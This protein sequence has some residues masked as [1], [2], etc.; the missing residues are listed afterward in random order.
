MSRRLPV[1]L[2]GAI[3]L[4][5]ATF[6]PELQASEAAL[7]VYSSSPGLQELALAD[8]AA[9]QLFRGR[10]RTEMDAQSWTKELKIGYLRFASPGQEDLQSHYLSQF[11]PRSLLSQV[12]HAGPRELELEE[13]LSGLGTALDRVRARALQALSDYERQRGQNLLLGRIPASIGDRSRLVS[14][15]E[16]LRDPAAILDLAPTALPIAVQYSDNPASMPEDLGLYFP[17]EEETPPDFLKH[18]A[19]LAKQQGLQY[20]LVGVIEALGIDGDYVFVEYLVYS[21][22][23]NRICLSSSF[24]SGR[25]E[26]AEIA[27][28]EARNLARRLVNRETSDLE[29]LVYP[30]VYDFELRDSLGLGAVTALGSGSFRYLA[31]GDLSLE[32]AYSASRRGEFS[33]WL[34]PEQ[35]A[36]WHV[37]APPPVSRIISVETE[38]AGAR[39][40]VDGTYAGLTPLLISTTANTRVLEFRKE[41]YHSRRLVLSPEQQR[42]GVK[43]PLLDNRVDWNRRVETTRDHFYAA[44]G[45]TILLGVLPVVFNGLYTD[46]AILARTDLENRELVNRATSFFWLRNGSLAIT[47]ASLILTFSALNDYTLAARA[48]LGY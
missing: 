27:G 19:N 37:A 45:T 7:T 39:L 15:A 26:A 30:P 42:T 20:L 11:I 21:S 46:A 24:I 8:P 29:L 44:L 13:R 2:L 18:L 25:S 41:G 34:E 12:P 14:V 17:L 36:L 10:V 43:V 33:T 3:L 4:A 47:G 1:F 48:A 16:V 40:L 31:S 32:I 23:A 6:T 5:A 28:E 22:L 9:L 38:P 35:E